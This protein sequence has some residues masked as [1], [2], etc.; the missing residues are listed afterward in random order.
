MK[1]ETLVKAC[2]RYFLSNFY[3]SSNDS[4]LKTM[5]NIF[6]FIKK[7]LSVLKIFT[8]LYFRLPF[9]FSLSAIALEVDPKKILTFMTLSTA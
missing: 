8:Y 6:Y 9:F 4:P 1:H 3:F 2:V 5:K 7:A